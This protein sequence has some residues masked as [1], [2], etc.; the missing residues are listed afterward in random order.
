MLCRVE[1]SQAMPLLGCAPGLFK[2]RHA[3]VKPC[4]TSALGDEICKRVR[5]LMLQNPGEVGRHGGDATNWHPEFSVIDGA[6]PCWR[7]GHVEV[8]LV[9]IKDHVDALVRTVGEVA[10]E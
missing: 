10:G 3:L 9:G 4:G 5:Q 2:L 7:L 1:R 8:L 6:A